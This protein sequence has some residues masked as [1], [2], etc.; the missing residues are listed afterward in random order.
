MAGHDLA[1]RLLRPDLRDQTFA[2]MDS[3][4]AIAIAA[5]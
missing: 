3:S 2:S 5:A 4:A 1:Y